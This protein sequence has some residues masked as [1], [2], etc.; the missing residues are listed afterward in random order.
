MWHI[1]QCLKNN[2]V[3]FNSFLTGADSSSNEIKCVEFCKI[4]NIHYA[5]SF[6]WHW[7]YLQ[8]FVEWR[9][10]RCRHSEPMLSRHQS[11][12]A[13]LCD[14]GHLHVLQ[15]YLIIFKDSFCFLCPKNKPADALT[16][17]LEMLL[18]FYML[19]RLPE[20]CVRFLSNSDWLFQSFTRTGY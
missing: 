9:L 12:F 10:C 8:L 4:Y 18:Y 7:V 2:L 11:H 15:R 13:E 3:V 19:G 16:G 20:S 6:F 5:C 17:N 1:S 14:H